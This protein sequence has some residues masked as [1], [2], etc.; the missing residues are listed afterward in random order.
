MQTDEDLS[1]RDRNR[2]AIL[3]EIMFRGPIA[4]AKIADRIGLTAATVS[5]ISR[6]LIDGG[7]VEEDQASEDPNRRGR[8]FIGLKVR[9]KGCFVAGIS[10][11]A[12]RQDIVLADM[13]NAVLASQRIHI[14]DLSNPEE[15]LT[16]SVNEL[17]KLIDKADVNRER[18]ISCGVAITGA[19]DPEK[20]I[21]RSSP[22]LGW[23][24]VNVSEIIGQNL[25]IPIFL[26]SI[27]NAKNLTAHSFGSTQD[28]NNVLLF[29]ASLAIGCSIL[30]DGRLIRGSKGNAGLIENMNIWD[31]DS[32]K[33]KSID[34]I[35]G[36]ISVLQKGETSISNN[37]GKLAE[38][39]INII[40]AGDTVDKDTAKRLE[41]AGSALGYVI[42]MS[43]ALL[44]P[45]VIL[46]SG[47]LVESNIYC[48]AVRQRLKSLNSADFIHDRLRFHP[49]SSYESAQSLAIY[50][51]LVQ[52]KISQKLNK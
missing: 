40:N 46:V 8:R 20:G 34:Q 48:D 21:L 45:D 25:D 37:P 29:N 33:Y 12:F 6:E 41:R 27:P 35:A 4:R 19:I 31:H 36:G 11:N 42:S 10:I 32:H 9:P 7:I 17:N 44:H 49:M 43:H 5:R 15:V 50:Q 13:S 3:A 52:C 26:E 22:A 38:K 14:G 51:S 18:L 2:R 23:S 47:P 30:L 28:V 1:E 16:K 24:T 39:L